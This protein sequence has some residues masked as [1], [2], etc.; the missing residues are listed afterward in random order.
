MATKSTTA[1]R[2]PAAAEPGRL[3]LICLAGWAVPGAA[4]LWLG[5]RQ[6]A[7]VFFVALTAMFAIGLSLGG[8]LFP[9]EFSEPL[10]VGPAIAE[11]AM[12]LPW[13]VARTMGWGVGAF[14]AVTHESGNTFLIVAGLLNVLVIIDAFD[15]A[16]GR[17]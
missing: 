1:D 13:I 2:A 3:V 7:I 17:K 12:G 14:T 10:V 15:V 5:R 4:H 9:F 6:K 8:M 11:L 16:L